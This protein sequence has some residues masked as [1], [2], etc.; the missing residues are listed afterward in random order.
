MELIT[1]GFEIQGLILYLVFC[2]R[3]FL[4]CFALY[5]LCYMLKLLFSQFLNSITGLSLKATQFLG[6]QPK[7]DWQT[8]C[9]TKSFFCNAESRCFF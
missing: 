5:T 8:M 1:I 2:P 4:Q 7:V 9:Q 6:S 3:T